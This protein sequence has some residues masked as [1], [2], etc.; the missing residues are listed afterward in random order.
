MP[1]Y[2]FSL[3]IQAAGT[4]LLLILFLLVYQKIRLRPLFEWIISWAF[5]F[6]AL[7]LQWLEPGLGQRRDLLFLDHAALILHAVFLVR[8][9]RLLRDPEGS[10]PRD[11]LWLLPALPLAALTSSSLSSPPALV[12]LVL[13]A[14]YLAVSLSLAVAPGSTVGR[15]LLSISFLLWG[16]EHW[17][18]RRETQNDASWWDA[19]QLF[20]H[21]AP[22]AVQ[23][24]DR[25]GAG[26]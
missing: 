9:I 12:A 19:G 24:T 3:L 26:A 15:L 8:G 22:P 1:V 20:L 2:P 6:G 13:A 4:A 25:G 11:L 7:A 23:L 10:R 5:L 14:T 21:S 16:V 18:M 17:Y